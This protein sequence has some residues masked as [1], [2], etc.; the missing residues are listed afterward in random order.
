MTSPHGPLIAQRFV[1]EGSLGTGGMGTVHVALDQQTGRR[2]ALK[3]LQPSGRPDD[4][5]R[6]TR[7]AQ[8]L[9]EL[10]HPHIVGH[11]AHG[12]DASGAAFLAMELLEGEDLRQRLRRGRMTVAESVALLDGASAA[13]AEAHRI[14]IVHRD[15]KPGNLFLRGGEAAGVVVLDFGVARRLLRSSL[16]HTGLLVGTPE[17]MAP[18]QAR[19]GPEIGPPADVF[20]LGCVFYECLSG[21]APHSGEHVAAVLSKVLFEE[22]PL[23][24]GL[25]ESLP[26]PIAEL[27]TRMLDKDPAQRYPHGLA[28]HEAVR[29]VIA[30]GHASTG[31]L[32]PTMPS[33]ASALSPQEQQLFSLAVAVPRTDASATDSER[34][35]AVAAVLKPLRSFG[36]E[37]DVLADGSVVA[38]V[39]QSVSASDQALLAARC[40]LLMRERL[41]DHA[42]AVATGLGQLRGRVPIGESIDR[43]LALVASA[44]AA[45]PEGVLV[46]DLSERLLA[47][48]LQMKRRGSRMLLVGEQDGG[49]AE[50]RR[51][52]GLRTACV[53]RE[54][55]LASLD[56]ALSTCVDESAARA[57]GLVG[58]PGIG[59]SRL[60][61]EF[62]LGAARRHPEL[63]VLLGRG[64]LM[65]TGAVYGL[66]AEAIRGLCEVVVGQPPATQ[67]ERLRRRIGRHL[68]PASA[69]RIAAF[70][71][72]MCGVPGLG[73]GER[74]V[75]AAR[76]D[77][78]LMRDQVMQSFLDW[79]RAEVKHAPILLVLEDL[80]WADAASLQFVEQALRE[81]HERPLCVLALARPEV[82]SLFPAFWSSPT[83]Q[84]LPLRPI[85]RRACERLAQDVLRRALGGVAPEVVAR[86]VGQS[87][88]NPLYL[89][90][91][92]RAVAEGRGDELPG[93][94]LSMLM[95]RL[96]QL[97]PSAR[98][99]LCAGS[100][101]GETFTRGGAAA[102]LGDEPVALE[103]ALAL[104]VRGELIE[105]QRDG[106]ETAD[107]RFKFRHALA[108][109][110]AYG[111]LTADNKVVAHRLACAYLEQLG[112]VGPAVLAEHA[113]KGQVVELAGRL[114]VEAA[115]QSLANFDLDAAFA[116]AERALACDVQGALFGEARAIQ[117]S[118]AYFRLEQLSAY[119][120]A[121]AAVDALPPG[122]LWWARAL[123]IC[124]SAFLV[125]RR[126]AHAARLAHAFLAA[127]PLPEARGA[128]LAAGSMLSTFFAARGLRRASRQ[129]VD[130]IESAA[131]G[132]EDC[133]LGHLHLTLAWRGHYLEPDHEA[134]LRS[135]ERA[136]ELLRAAGDE[137]ALSQAMFCLGLA[138]LGLGQ[139]ERA[140]AAMREAMALSLGLGDAFYAVV[141]YLHIGLQLAE[142]G[143]PAAQDE[144]GGIAATFCDQ[145][146]LGPAAIG[147]A[148]VVL[149]LVR[150]REGR[151]VVAERAFELALECFGGMLPYRVMVVP[152]Y[153]D[154]LV[155]LERPDEARRLAEATLARIEA[156]GGLGAGELRVRL[157]VVEA[158]LAAGDLEGGRAALRDAL[159]ELRRRAERIAEP[160]LRGAYLE[161]PENRRLHDLARAHAATT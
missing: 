99:A 123:G 30:R 115:R 17:Y 132:L 71:G 67:Q 152:A 18:E 29:R 142:Q 102:L 36:A 20:A 101:F 112:G 107:E 159:A 161:R 116:Q 87:A 106:D 145:S 124:F 62:T 86:I 69:G 70:V 10:R 78:K 55:E 5:E 48:R 26:E 74:A 110:A 41:A 51:L 125:L 63:L 91:L 11:V 144:A 158:R 98:Q 146:E 83:L 19:G 160:G 82:Q 56:A 127:E 73:D 108:R 147:M 133:E 148:H 97:D 61:H 39:F 80:Q 54:Q 85:G 53:G 88:G 114:H 2:V 92:V 14:G 105:R 4:A 111:L 37:V 34:R 12:V 118:V 104:L 93:T 84:V 64:D 50:T 16:T 134:V 131:A 122:C 9:A 130:K 76:Q 94:V 136:V 137:T 141:I 120:H 155:R 151:P 66:L 33:L 150:L 77:P 156:Q 81:L 121:M 59:K 7:E 57:I 149:G 31:S 100:V 119:M 22:P 95:A 47:G 1:V 72:E 139:A 79:L 49:D 44:S 126:H 117:A 13:L 129:L 60:R 28:L 24:Q 40:G 27:M 35:E 153:V 96:S 68:P 90:E 157:A 128:Y 6:F 109:E 58:P 89:E 75:L 52:L 103:G 25:R 42:V 43:A 38:R 65:H 135:S 3:L 45:A 138:A 140:E 8:I 15:L 154:L 143:N 32:A 23:L 113:Q 21:H 46:D